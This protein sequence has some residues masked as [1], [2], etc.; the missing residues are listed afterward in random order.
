MFVSSFF[1]FI[2]N[3]LETLFN[4][5]FPSIFKIVLIVLIALIAQ[6]FIK[7]ATN[8]FRQLRRNGSSTIKP[9]RAE[10]LSQIVQS[11]SKVIIFVI[12]VLMILNELGLD[13]RPM[14]ASAGILGVAFSLGAQNLM[15][16]VINGFFILLEDQFGIGDVV[17]IGEISGKVLTMNLRTTTIKDTQ[18]ILHV[19][20]N[21][22]ISHVSLVSRE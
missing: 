16:D 6:Y 12:A 17:K 4:W 1:S 13:T 15:K 3:F 22:S 9:K 18:G 21:G 14:L 7:L 2:Q 11:T 20:S 19:I 10:T 5:V 8:K